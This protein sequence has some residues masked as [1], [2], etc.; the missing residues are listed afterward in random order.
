MDPTGDAEHD[1]AVARA[2]KGNLATLRLSLAQANPGLPFFT[3]YVA[4][5]AFPGGHFAT[6]AEVAF[7]AAQNQARATKEKSAR[8][9]R[10][11]KA[12]AAAKKKKKGEAEGGEGGEEKGGRLAGNK[13]KRGDK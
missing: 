5:H 10:S 2:M 3:S 6:Y 11:S 9:Q 1:K 7:R 13:R 4:P 8:R 12:R